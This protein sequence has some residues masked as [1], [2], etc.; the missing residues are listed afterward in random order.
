MPPP[1]ARINP[2]YWQ[3]RLRASA[4]VKKRVTA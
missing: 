1:P 3:Q 4:K 2:Q